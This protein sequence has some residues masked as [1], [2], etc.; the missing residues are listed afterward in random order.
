MSSVIVSC[1]LRQKYLNPENNMRSALFLNDCLFCYV[2]YFTLQKYAK[3][4]T[5][6]YLPNLQVWLV[7][8]FLA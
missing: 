2:F 3:K 4:V 5:L 1:N 6:K 7:N 8:K